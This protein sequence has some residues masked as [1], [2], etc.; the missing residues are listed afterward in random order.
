MAE[1]SVENWYNSRIGN[2]S[3]KAWI[4]KVDVDIHNNLSEKLSPIWVGLEILFL[5][6]Y[7]KFLYIKIN[8]LDEHF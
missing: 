1:G 7:K 4:S 6:Y 8:S 2:L 5:L 3:K